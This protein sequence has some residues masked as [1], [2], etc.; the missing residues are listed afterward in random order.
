[1]SEVQSAYL[2]DTLSQHWPGD[3]ERSGIDTFSALDDHGNTVE[4]ED[5]L[6]LIPEISAYSSV[7][8]KDTTPPSAILCQYLRIRD[9]GIQSLILAPHRGIHISS[10]RN[11]MS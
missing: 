6:K 3:A 9:E 10:G 4:H 2:P 5:M 7:H 8:H 1:M 11:A